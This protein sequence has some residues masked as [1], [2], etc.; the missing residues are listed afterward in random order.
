MEKKFRDLELEKFIEDGTRLMLKHDVGN[1]NELEQL[2]SR[3]SD[4][5]IKTIRKPI[6]IPQED[7]TTYAME[8][9]EVIDLFSKT[10]SPMF[11][12]KS[13]D[14]NRIEK[15]IARNAGSSGGRLFG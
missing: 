1:H 9:I 13:E 12:A 8:H 14:L 5:L 3:V 15:I 6:P 2:K 4:L 11:D 10:I 7:Q